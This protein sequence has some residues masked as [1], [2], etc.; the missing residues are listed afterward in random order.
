MLD[1]VDFQKFVDETV[2][3]NVLYEPEDGDQA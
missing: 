2:G 3:E 1:L